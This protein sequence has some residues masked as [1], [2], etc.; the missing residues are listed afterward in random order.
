MTPGQPAAH[1]AALMHQLLLLLLLLQTYHLGCCWHF[2]QL[3]QL[4]LRRQVCCR[5][6]LLLLCHSVAQAAA[7]LLP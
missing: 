1:T 6:L 4:H 7:L 3:L 2:L 5:C